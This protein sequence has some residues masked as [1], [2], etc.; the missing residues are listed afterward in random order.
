[1]RASSSSVNGY[2]TSGIR[3]SAIC[4]GSRYQP[5]NGPD[6]RYMVKQMTSGANTLWSLS[7]LL[8]KLN[9]VLRG[10]G[11]YY[12]FCT[13]ASRQFAALDF[14]VGDCIWRWL[15]KKHTKLHRKRTRLVRL[16]SLLRPTRKLWR[17]G[18]VEQFLLSML[19]VERFRRGWMRT[20]AYIGVPGEP[21]A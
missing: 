21:D 2:A 10:W 15:M 8:Q 5:A 13:G 19:R 17:E 18:K 11:N 9:P 3:A 7:E 12:R 1:M 14:Y 16:P 20:P 4:R 6:L